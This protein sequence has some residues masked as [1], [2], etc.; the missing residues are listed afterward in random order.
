MKSS[1]QQQVHR[2]DRL[3]LLCTPVEMREEKEKDV[4]AHVILAV[5]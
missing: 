4:I 2:A 1:E 5:L 3:A